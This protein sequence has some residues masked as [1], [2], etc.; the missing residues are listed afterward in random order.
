[1]LIKKTKDIMGAVLNMEGHCSSP[2]LFVSNWRQS[3]ELGRGHPQRKCMPEGETIPFKTG[4]LGLD[5]SK[6]AVSWLSSQFG[7][8][9]SLM[10]FVHCEG[11]KRTSCVLWSK[12]LQSGMWWRWITRSELPSTEL[13][14]TC[15]SSSVKLGALIQRK[16]RVR[17]RG[18]SF[19][20]H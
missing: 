4:I 15:K 1:M 16:I 17:Y 18:E 3:H 12:T 8:E 19:Q 10:F 14:G 2:G 11:S 20:L 6:E 9:C 13:V 7:L 5:S